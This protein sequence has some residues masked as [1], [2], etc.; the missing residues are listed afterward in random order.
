MYAKRR[1]KLIMK[2]DVKITIRLDIQVRD[3]Y[4]EYCNKN[5]YSLSKRIR[6]LLKNDMSNKLIINE[7]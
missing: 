2:K 5:G 6:T 3:N 4:K 1:T 7:K